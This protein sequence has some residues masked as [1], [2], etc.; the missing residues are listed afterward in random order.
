V[1]AALLDAIVSALGSAGRV[2]PAL[3]NKAELACICQSDAKES[4]LLLDP[5]TGRYDAAATPSTGTDT[6]FVCSAGLVSA[7]TAPECAGH[8][9]F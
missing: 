7:T 1:T 6:L 5:A 4:M 2:A 3:A 9:V 8:A